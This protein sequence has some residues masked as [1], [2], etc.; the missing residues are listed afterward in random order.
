MV[1]S[2]GRP[3]VASWKLI[4]WQVEE[5][6]K[7]LTAVESVGDWNSYAVYLWALSVFT[8]KSLF[9]SEAIIKYVVHKVLS[10]PGLHFKILE[11][12]LLYGDITQDAH[13]NLLTCRIICTS[14][15]WMAIGLQESG[16][17]LAF[18]P[19]N[20]TRMLM[21]LAVDEC[22]FYCGPNFVYCSKWSFFSVLNEHFYFVP[23]G[24]WMAT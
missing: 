14:G 1:Y 2:T 12:W 19:G 9:N 18:P 5:K 20:G 4:S 21:K 23:S 10:F 15:I 8:A 11:Y 17:H 16:E 3:C 24:R 22:K 6:G 13:N 7:I